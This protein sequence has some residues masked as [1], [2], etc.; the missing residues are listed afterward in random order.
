MEWIW[1]V[2]PHCE[3]GLL[4][5]CAMCFLSHGMNSLVWETVIYEKK[6][7]CSVRNVRKPWE[8]KGGILQG[9]DLFNFSQNLSAE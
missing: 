9:Y 5:T 1:S 4:K 2:C 8:Q 6:T 7:S 3:R